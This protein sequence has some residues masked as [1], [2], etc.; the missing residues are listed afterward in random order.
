MGVA[1]SWWWLALRGCLLW[2][3]SALGVSAPGGIPACT[4]ADPHPSGQTDRCKNVTFTTSLR[5]I[6]IVIIGS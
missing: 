5:T 3:V 2:L 4:E 1:C 6:I